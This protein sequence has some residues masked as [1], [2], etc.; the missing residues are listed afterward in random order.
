MTKS[1]PEKKKIC[2]KA[3]FDKRIILLIIM[4]K[5]ENHSSIIKFR[6]VS[7]EY[8]RINNN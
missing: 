3:D 4:K 7:R 1:K 8:K 6:K 5:Y 2:D